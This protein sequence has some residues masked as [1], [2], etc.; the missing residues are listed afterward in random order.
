MEPEI[1][2]HHHTVFSDALSCRRSSRY[3]N[4]AAEMLSTGKS[5]LSKDFYKNRDLQYLIGLSR[6]VSEPALN[7]PFTSWRPTEDDVQKDTMIPSRTEAVKVCCL[8]CLKYI[9]FI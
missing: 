3:M 6:Y 9:I 8:S 4:S 7:G 5:G 1:H 2:E